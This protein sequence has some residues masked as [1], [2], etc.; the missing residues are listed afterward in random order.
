[1][2]IEPRSAGA[3]IMSVSLPKP[4]STTLAIP[5]DPDHSFPLLESGQQ[6]SATEFMRRYEATP[7]LENVELI[8]G[9]VHVA[10]PVSAKFHGKPHSTLV[11]WIVCYVARTPPGTGRADNSTAILEVENVPQPDC[12]LYLLPRQG[13]RS[14]INEGGYVVGAPELVVEVSA[15]TVAID[16]NNKLPAYERNGIREYIIYR[17][18]D[19]LVDWYVL[20]NGSYEKLTP[21]ADGT[22]RSPTFPGL[23]LDPDALF[24]DDLASL[25]KT[26]DQGIASPEHAEFVSRIHPS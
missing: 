3:P 11:A 9:V 22:L 2:A 21:S 8:E 4:F 23:W 7:D 1:M 12:M 15:S 16:R 26:L 6:L 20:R 19:S 13:G 10:S 18:L 25:F 14:H 17:V 5:G 24:R